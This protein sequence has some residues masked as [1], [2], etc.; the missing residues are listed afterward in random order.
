[1]KLT[2]L[3][4]LLV[5]S[6][7][8]ELSTEQKLKLGPIS[9]RCVSESG[10]TLDDLNLV[11]L[12]PSYLNPRL[13]KHSLCILKRTNI[14]TE[15]GDIDTDVIKSILGREG[16]SREKVAEIMKCAVKKSTPEDTA[17][18]LRTCLKKQPNF[19]PAD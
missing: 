5:A 14:I 3:L 17:V 10:A 12:S 11:R 9:R 1:M 18:E 4:L 2:F 8:A 16:A 15:S 19:S 13:K 7:L 6:A